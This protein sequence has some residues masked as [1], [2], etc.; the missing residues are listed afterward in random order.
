VDDACLGSIPDVWSK[1]KMRQEA[2]RYGGAVTNISGV[3]VVYSESGITARVIFD[4]NRGKV[5]LDGQKFY[6]EKK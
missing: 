2:G 6:I 4:T 3:S 5:E 1:E